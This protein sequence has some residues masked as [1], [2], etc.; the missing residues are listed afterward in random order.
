MDAAICA[1]AGKTAQVQ[2]IL[3]GRPECQRL[4]HVRRVPRY[5]CPIPISIA[6]HIKA[7]RPDAKVRLRSHSPPSLEFAERAA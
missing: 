4:A 6:Q 2:R 5:E 1:K 3:K 7:K